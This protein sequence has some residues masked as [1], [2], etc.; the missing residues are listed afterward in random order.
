MAN[1]CVNYF[2]STYFFSRIGLCHYHEVAVSH[3]RSLLGL[4]RKAPLQSGEKRYVTN[5]IPNAKETETEYE[6]EYAA[7]GQCRFR[8][9]G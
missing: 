3:S 2:H 7:C 9:S 6:T 4:S 1:I 8:S 5:Q